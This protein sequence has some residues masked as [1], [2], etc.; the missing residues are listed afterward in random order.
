MLVIEG[1]QKEEG[2]DMETAMREVKDLMKKG[3]GRKEAVSR[4]A[5]DYGL[6]KKE[7]YD[8]SLSG[9]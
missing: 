4:V 2:H 3:V 5:K 8:R 7:L 1:R 6:S 9:E